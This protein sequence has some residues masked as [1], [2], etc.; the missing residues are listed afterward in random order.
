MGFPRQEYWRRL[1]FPSP[2][3]LPSTGIEP[4]SPA[5][6]ADSLPLS[7][8]GNPFY[9]E[10]I[11]NHSLQNVSKTCIGKLRISFSKFTNFT[12]FHLSYPLCVY[13]SSSFCLYSEREWKTERERRTVFLVPHSKNLP[14]QLLW[15]QLTRSCS[16]IL[17]QYLL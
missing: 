12:T 16:T 10:I 6:K 3:D 2:G 17:L 9:F 7:H 5:W 15:I 8:L 4:L 13:L 1:P 14:N 11:S